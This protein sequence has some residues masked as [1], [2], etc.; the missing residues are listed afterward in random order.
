M[1]DQIRIF[2]VCFLDEII[3]TK[4]TILD[5]KI[6]KV[7]KQNKL[8]GRDHLLLIN[9]QGLAKTLYDRLFSLFSR[10]VQS[11]YPP[12]MTSHFHHYF[13]SDFAVKSWLAPI[14][15]RSF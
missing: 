4:S 11:Q 14:A 10:F 12:T 3:V 5:T 9:E 6:I 2:G 7:S 8:V 13:C 1:I 15:R